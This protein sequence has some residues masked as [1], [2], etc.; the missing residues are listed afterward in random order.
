CDVLQP[1]DRLANLP[2]HFGQLLRPEQQEGHDQDDQN[3]RDTKAKHG[4]MTLLAGG[5]P[6]DAPPEPTLRLARILTCRRTRGS[7]GGG[8]R[9]L[10]RR[11]SRLSLRDLL[12]LRLVDCLLESFDGFSEAFTQLGELTCPEH[13]EDDNQN[14]QQFHPA[15]SEHLRHLFC[16]DLAEPAN[17]SSRTDSHVLPI[18][19]AGI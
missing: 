10:D 16:S 12:R 9:R 18:I 3:L 6:A 2:A 19:W 7:T 15:K 14:Q 8:R 1:L 11:R 5:G 17:S 4:R 13:D